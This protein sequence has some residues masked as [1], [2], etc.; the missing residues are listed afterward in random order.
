MKKVI[1]E[2]ASDMTF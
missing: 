2:I 1:S